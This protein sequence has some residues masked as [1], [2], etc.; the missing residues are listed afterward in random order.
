MLGSPLRA[1]VGIQVD[2]WGWGMGVRDGLGRHQRNLWRGKGCGLLSSCRT[3]PN[4]LILQI[5]KGGLGEAAGQGSPSERSEA[6]LHR[7]G[8]AWGWP[9]PGTGGPG[10]PGGRGR[11]LPAFWPPQSSAFVLSLCFPSVWP[12]RPSRLPLIV[13]RVIKGQ[14]SRRSLA[15]V[16]S[17]STDTMAAGGWPRGALGG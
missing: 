13:C 8:A 15:A 5:R 11:R 1:E 7:G 14:M 6:S 4:S 2:F 16:G 12:Q 10:W 3:L 17:P 9:R